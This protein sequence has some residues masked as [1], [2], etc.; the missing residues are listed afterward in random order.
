M[1]EEGRLSWYFIHPDHQG[2]GIGKALAGHCI[3][4]LQDLESIK[5]LVVRTS[6]H[7][8]KFFNKMGFEKEKVVDN[9]WAPGFHL[10]QMRMNK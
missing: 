3:Q 5:F 2:K 7:A 10:Y 1:G 8:W 6:Q 4:C 9:F